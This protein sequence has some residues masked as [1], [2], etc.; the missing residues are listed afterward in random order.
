[1]TDRGTHRCEVCGEEF[2]TERELDRHVHDVGIV[3]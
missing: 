2:D 1:M 3:D